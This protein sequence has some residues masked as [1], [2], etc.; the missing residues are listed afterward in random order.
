MPE[1]HLIDLKVVVA[2]NPVTVRANLNASLHSVL[3]KAL[4]LS[5]NSGQ[6][7]SNWELKDVNGNPY[8]LSRKVGDFGFVNGSVLYLN[9]RI[10]I[11]G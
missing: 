7:E 9:Q 3:S 11:G 1:N 5:G 2:G 8:D 6:P 4:E 10:G